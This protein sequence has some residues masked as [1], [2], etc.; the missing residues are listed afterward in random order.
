MV[1]FPK[2]QKLTAVV[3]SKEKVSSK[4]YLVR[5]KL[6]DPPTITFHAG[7]NIMLMIAPGVNRT[8]SIASPPSENTSILMAHDV[9]PGGP[10][11]Q[12]TLNLKVGDQVNLIG[13]TGALSFDATSRRSKVFA[14]TG[15]GIAPFRAMILEYLTNGGTD[16][17]TLYWGL[18]HKEDIFWL[19]EFTSLSQQHPN[20]RFIL[21]LSQPREVLEEGPP[22]LK[23]R[24]V[25]GHVTEHVFEEQRN[26]TGNDY[27]LCGNR[28]MVQEMEKQ[29]LTSNVP[30]TQIHKELFY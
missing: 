19:D 7:Q 21:C 4:V 14:A 22:S 9:S 27:Y 5:F 25:K 13:P 26:L 17:V 1:S 23:L 12:W 8:M 16:D 18:R 29:L 28:A 3:A 2:P 15:V 6:V 11:S 10:G 24:R 30:K 20:F